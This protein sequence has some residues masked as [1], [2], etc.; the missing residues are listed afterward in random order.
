[1]RVL[2]YLLFFIL[3]FPFCQIVYA[4][5]N[6]LYAS[7]RLVVNVDLKDI[8]R[9]LSIG[10]KSQT[11]TVGD[12]TGTIDR[13]TS[14]LNSS[15][16]GL[17]VE[18]VALQAIG[19]GRT[20]VCLAL[21]VCLGVGT[22]ISSIDISLLALAGAVFGLDECLVGLEDRLKLG[23][24]DV[25]EEDTFAELAIGNGESLLAITSLSGSCQR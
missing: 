13:N 18:T 24:L 17:V 25:V 2:V 23:K 6:Q 16:L 19:S 22:E 7:I 21:D 8:S 15:G 20:T 4:V 9:V 10:R 5:Q 12:M 14:S 3:F 1:M 11:Y